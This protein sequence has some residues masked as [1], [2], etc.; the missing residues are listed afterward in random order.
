MVNN[1]SGKISQLKSVNSISDNWNDNLQSLNR[2]KNEASVPATGANL[3]RGLDAS[4]SPS[5]VKF[6]RIGRRF[7]R[8]LSKELPYMANNDEYIDE[9]NDEYLSRD[10]FASF[11][12][13]SRLS[14]IP[15]IRISSSLAPFTAAHAST[16]LTPISVTQ[17]EI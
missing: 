2:E 1:A 10:F 3:L 17:V 6:T 5:N 13:W 12:F 9:C 7:H 4:S 16:S 11:N 14:Y 8:P 15:D